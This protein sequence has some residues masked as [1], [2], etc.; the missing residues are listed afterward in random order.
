M[1]R[2]GKY[3]LC[4]LCQQPSTLRRSHIRPRW[5]D[6][7]LLEEKSSKIQ[8]HAGIAR[9]TQKQLHVFLLCESCEGLLSRDER[10]ASIVLKRERYRIQQAAIAPTLC[11]AGQ[12]AIPMT[13]TEADA[14]ERYALSTLWRYARFCDFQGDFEA[15]RELDP[16]MRSRLLNPDVQVDT[17]RW[18]TGISVLGVNSNHPLRPTGM[19]VDWNSKSGESAIFWCLTLGFVLWFQPTSWLAARRFSISSQR[20]IEVRKMPA[21]LDFL[22]VVAGT[23][24]DRTS[25]RNN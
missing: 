19:H 3:G 24:E 4:G 8:V 1:T 11:A 16:D 9:S 13:R 18:N 15:L 21:L 2:S 25:V 5:I 23:A 7:Q 14:V 20:T 22:C 12:S 6:R 17:L 10:I